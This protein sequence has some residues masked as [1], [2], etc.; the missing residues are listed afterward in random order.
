MSCLI[1]DHY[2]L[3]TI[4]STHNYFYQVTG[5]DRFLGSGL[6][7]Q[8]LMIQTKGSLKIL[9]WS[10]SRAWHGNIGKNHSSK[11]FNAK[12]SYRDRMRRLL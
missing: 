3:S 9:L 2:L 10:E 11:T 1:T 8:S 12:S 7:C 5:V 4:I 6:I